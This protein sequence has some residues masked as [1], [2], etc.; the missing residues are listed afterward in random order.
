MR[1]VQIVKNH[2]SNISYFEF[3]QRLACKTANPQLYISAICFIK[4]QTDF[5][6]SRKFFKK[7]PKIKGYKEKVGR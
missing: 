5:I 6:T 7:D 2:I 3:S 4:I 1:D